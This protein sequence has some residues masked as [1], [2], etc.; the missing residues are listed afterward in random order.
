ME[1]TPFGGAAL[2]Y[3]HIQNNG[4]I[5]FFF[6]GESSRSV[7]VTGSFCGWKIPGVGLQRVPGGWS[8]EVGPVSEGP[9]AYKFLVDGRWTADPVNITREGDHDESNSLLP[10]RGRGTTLHLRFWSPALREERRYTLYLPPS[11]GTQGRRFPT[12][13]LLH[14]LLDW[15][16]TW[17][18]KGA[19]APTLDRM[20]H[21]GMVGEMIVVMPY[22]NGLLHR[23]DTRIADY[24]ARDL[25]GHIDHEFATLPEQS[26]RALDGLST[27]GFTSLIVGA[28]RPM[29]FRSVGSMSGSHDN[30]TFSTIRSCSGAM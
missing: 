30:R 29:V 3:T 2:L 17:L 16:R 24:L 25:V 10:G 9:V 20:I 6:P 14:G 13:Y 26:A 22:E 1:I 28:W 18:D 7:S 19:L 4:R 11:Y 15:E 12:L 5:F 23:G 21:Q 27:G 8:A